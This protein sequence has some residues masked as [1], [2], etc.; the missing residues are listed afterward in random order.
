MSDIEKILAG[1]F[2]GIIDAYN[3]VTNVDKLPYATFQTSKSPVA[4]KDGVYRYD[5]NVEI[6]IVCGNFDD[7]KNITGKIV[8]NLFALRND[9]INVTNLSESGESDSDIYVKKI[10]CLIIELL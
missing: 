5:H 3:T 7:C 4:N 10:E 9:D 1:I 8:K 6:N 2:E